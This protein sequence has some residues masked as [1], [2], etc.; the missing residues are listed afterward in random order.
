M[1][2]KY[3]FDPKQEHDQAIIYIVWYLIKT[4]DLG[5][6][7]KLDALKGFYCYADTDFSGE[8]NKDFAKLDPSKAKSRSPSCC[9]T[10]NVLLDKMREPHFQIICITPRFC[11]KAFDDNSGALELARL[12]KL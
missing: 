10:H 2:A 11:C 12:P 1:V 3:S 8:W 5:L 6:H 9:H 4:C 7:F